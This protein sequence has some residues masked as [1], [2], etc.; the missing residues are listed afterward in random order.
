[1]KTTRPDGGA[2]PIGRLYDVT[3]RRRLLH[4]SGTGSPAVVFFPGAG[5]VG[6]DS[7]T[8]QGRAAELTMSVLFDH[9]GTG[10]SDPVELPRTAAGVPD[11]YLLVGHSL[12]GIYSHRYAQL[13]PVE[14]AGLLLLDPAHEGYLE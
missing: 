2:P 4:R 1:M 3:G 14:V 9:A 11:P 10:W 7:L 13:F 6:P 5:L 12:G 8:V